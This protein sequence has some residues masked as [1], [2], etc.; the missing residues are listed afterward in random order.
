M[1]KNKSGLFKLEFMQRGIQNQ[2]ERAKNEAEKLMT[3]LREEMQ[4]SMGDEG[5]GA[6]SEDDFT[7][8][9]NKVGIGG[10]G[11]GGSNDDDDDDVDDDEDGPNAGGKGNR[12][13]DD[14]V[15]GRKS[16]GFTMS[17]RGNIRIGG[18]EERINDA[19]RHNRQKNGGAANDATYDDNPWV[20]GATSK[21]KNQLKTAI[22]ATDI[23][24]GVE[25][26]GQTTTSSSKKSAFISNDIDTDKSD[27]ITEKS[28]EELV[29]QAFAADSSFAE[30]EFR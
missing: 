11:D 26:L 19:S 23:S 27:S 5:G 24:K 6:D 22:D 15:V 7:Y 25:L 8:D 3:E 13:D 17:V 4:E 29:R 12:N 10:G 1:K 28:Q 2:R 16:A 18:E 20:K 30:E 9:T 21:K 14:D